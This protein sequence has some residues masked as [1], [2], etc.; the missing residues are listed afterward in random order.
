MVLVVCKQQNQGYGN[1]LYQE[2]DKLQGKKG[3]LKV[4]E[5]MEAKDMYSS[6]YP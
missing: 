4:S 2:F 1:P 6:L 3:K 5:N